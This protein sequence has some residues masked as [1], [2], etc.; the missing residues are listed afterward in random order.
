MKPWNLTKEN[1][2]NLTKKL[3]DLDFSKIWKVVV[4]EESV[5][6][7]T[8][9]NSRL[10]GFLYPSIGNYLG[11]S[12]NEIHEL[13]KYKFLREERVIGGEVIVSIKS[14]ARLKVEEFTEYMRDVEVWA[15]EL[16]WSDDS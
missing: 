2:P 8:E 11:Y 16:G 6:R 7:S 14:T 1:L 4:Y 10:W 12:A 9:Q 5:S 3:S 13:C 15:A